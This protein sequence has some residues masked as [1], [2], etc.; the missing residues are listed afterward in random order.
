[1]TNVS[2]E[3]DVASLEARLSGAIT[4]NI[5]LRLGEHEFPAR[6]WNDFAVVISE[7]WASALQ[8]LLEGN[9]SRELVD[10][11][12][13]PYA[14]EITA[15]SSGELS[16]RTLRGVNRETQVTSCQGVPATLF[17]QDFIG[18]ARD[19]LRAC[20]RQNYWTDDVKGLQASLNLLSK[21]LIRKGNCRK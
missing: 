12:D 6:N 17:I 16:F 2:F 11:M 8:R 5:C 9:S 14:V 13:G 7:W 18:Q 3:I 1:M 19:L 20:E 4:A 10:F 21:E 15:T